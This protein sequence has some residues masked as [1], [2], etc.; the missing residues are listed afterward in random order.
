MFIKT[1][2]KACNILFRLVVFLLNY[3]YVVCIRVF[4]VTC[5]FAT[6]QRTKVLKH[7]NKVHNIDSESCAGYVETNTNQRHGGLDMSL[8]IDLK[9]YFK[10]SKVWKSTFINTETMLNVDD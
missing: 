5:K 1:S 3:C 6:T 7:I 9:I 10:L 4:C 2:F 8:I